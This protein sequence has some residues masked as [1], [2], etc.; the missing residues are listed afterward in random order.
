MDCALYWFRHDLRLTDNP[1]FSRACVRSRTPV[2]VYVV[3]DEEQ[4]ATRLR[5]HPM[6][7]GWRQGKDRHTTSAERRTH[8]LMPTISNA[9]RPVQLG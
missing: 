4:V 7:P 9:M 2:P 8:D 1:G 5:V 3:D 6:G